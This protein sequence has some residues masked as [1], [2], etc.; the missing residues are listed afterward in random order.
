MNDLDRRI[1]DC[2]TRITQRNK[3]TAI[4]KE[5]HQNRTA[6][7]KKIAQLKYALDKEIKDLEKLEGPSFSKVIFTI[8][9]RL[10]EKKDK[11]KGEAAEA[12][13]KHDQAVA[14]ARHNENLIKRYEAKKTNLA[15]CEQEY[16]TLLKEKRKLILKGHTAESDELFKLMDDINV[17]KSNL[18]EVTEALESGSIAQS[19]VE[20]CLS[21]LVTAEDWGA[22]DVVGGGLMATAIKHEN[23]DMANDEMKNAHTALVNFKTELADID[24]DIKSTEVKLGNFSRFADYFLGGIIADLFVMEKIE[25]STESVEEQLSSVK[26]V[27]QELRIMRNKYKINIKRLEELLEQKTIKLSI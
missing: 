16:Q 25:K 2:L 26:S 12:K 24:F 14:D 15:G 8:S 10:T 7:E 13:L 11:E 9:C 1:D 5:L 19:S 20:K 27:M 22:Y 6:L 18:L 17:L 21:Y 4:L 3:A 23:I